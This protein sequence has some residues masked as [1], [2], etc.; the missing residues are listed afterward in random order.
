MTSD[1]QGLGLVHTRMGIVPAWGGSSR[2]A[3][4]VGS[5]KALELIS[6]GRI[7]ASDEALQIG[8]IDSIVSS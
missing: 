2:L 3:A 7:V 6:S 5:R 1:C 4:I 8:L